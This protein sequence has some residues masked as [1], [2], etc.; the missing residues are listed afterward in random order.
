MPYGR[1]FAV[2]GI[3]SDNFYIQNIGSADLDLML[4]YVDSFTL[5]ATKFTDSPQEASNARV[6]WEFVDL[7]CGDVYDRS[8]LP[9]DSSTKTLPAS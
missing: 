1:V 3:V 5:D 7:T 8:V 6:S 4:T 9:C 2:S